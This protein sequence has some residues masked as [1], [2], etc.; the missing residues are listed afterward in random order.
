MKRKFLL[1]VLSVT[2]FF[3][4]SALPCFA[5]DDGIS[6]VIGSVNTSLREN[7]ITDRFIEPGSYAG[8]IENYS[9]NKFSLN[10]SKAIILNIRAN[11][12]FQFSRGTSPV[13]TGV[14]LGY[15]NFTVFV[16][17]ADGTQRQANW[18][19]TYCHNNMPASDITA[20]YS[21]GN[22]I[23]ECKID[24]TDKQ[25]THITAIDVVQHFYPSN[26][27][28][29]WT[30]YFRQT[31]TEFSLVHFSDSDVVG[32][33]GNASDDITNSINQNGDKVSESIDKQTQDILGA[34]VPGFDDT[35]NNQTQAESQLQ[36]GFSDLQG[37]VNK[38]DMK[39]DDLSAFGNSFVLIADGINGIF[40]GLGGK[41][42]I[43]WNSLVFFG[44]VA[45]L[46]GL[47]VP[48]AGL[49]S[50]SEKKERKE[51]YKRNKTKAGGGQD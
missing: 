37:M 15:W 17:F 50:K 31:I 5:A 24:V 29:Y 7:V 35:M 28:P 11:S 45:L 46:L 36:S 38:P 23:F 18:N 8:S 39:L 10:N 3:S 13:S 9:V 21:A 51:S 14:Y 2:L 48:V 30:L 41:F 40:D 42:R 4:F 25:G 27:N 1:L 34:T 19:T 22:K 32:S 20:R 47:A 44:G 26:I 16:T 12:T 49:A 33:I 43:V 6:D